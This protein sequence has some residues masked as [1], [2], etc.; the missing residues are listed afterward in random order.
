MIPAYNRAHL[1]GEA[2]DSV[3]CQT[4][5]PDEVIVVD[6]GSTDDTVQVV[7]R[8]ADRNS[9]PIKIIQQSNGGAASARN[10]AI[11][12][13]DADLIA[14]LDSDDVWVPDHVQI[15]LQAFH[16]HPNLVVSA[17]NTKRL[18]DLPQ[19]KRE[20]Y[21]E[22]L[23]KKFEYDCDDAGL[24][25]IRGSAF[26][27]LLKGAYIQTSSCI[28]QRAAAVEVGLFDES[29]RSYEDQLFF[30]RLSRLGT[31][32]L[33]MAPVT[34][35]RKHDDNTTHRRHIASHIVCAI[36]A[37]T[38]ALGDAD[39]MKLSDDEVAAVRGELTRRTGRAMERASRYGIRPYWTVCRELTRRGLV[40]S[41]IRP[42]P[43]LR[44]LI[45]P[46]GDTDKLQQIS[47]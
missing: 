26:K 11:R 9:F 43:L 40:A 22:E 36:D 35:L 12:Q 23:F 28:F 4:R 3:A 14:P 20:A 30:L 25:I 45:H 46:K 17:G 15:L 16:N 29:L 5:V 34:L 13:T 31:F 1:I 38:I 33:Y 39:K 2:L 21:G 41:L 32:G 44:A 10:T 8:W 24:R 37:L 7:Q 27:S 47:N 19:F 42:K 18:D 6:D